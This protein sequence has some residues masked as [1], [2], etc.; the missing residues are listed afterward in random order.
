MEGEVRAAMRTLATRKG[1][2][3]F[4]AYVPV[5][6]LGTR[7]GVDARVQPVLGRAVRA[8]MAGWTVFGHADIVPPDFPVMVTSGSSVLLDFGA[9]AARR[10]EIGEIVFPAEKRTVTPEAVLE[11][12]EEHADVAFSFD[13]PIPHGLDPIDAGRRRELT[14]A[15]A[16]WALGARRRKDLPLYACVQGWDRESY[17][18]CAKAYRGRPFDGLAIGGLST[19]AG[20]LSTVLS[21]VEAVLEEADGRF[22][23]VFNL[24]DPKAVGIL[25]KEGVD[26]V[27]SNS[28]LSLANEGRFWHH[29]SG[30]LLKPSEKDKETIALWNLSCASGRKM[31]TVAAEVLRMEKAMEAAAAARAPSRSARTD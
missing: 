16:L 31:E 14:V 20:N 13:F 30:R 12:Q 9:V 26:S 28:W 11:V 17:R 4:P 23:H 6:R 3:R 19:R 1:R 5:T 2:I 29:P 22:V 24:G 7:G 25:L 10:G 15:C 27:S 8:A 21:I 18:W